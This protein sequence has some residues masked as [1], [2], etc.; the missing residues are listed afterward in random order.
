MLRTPFRGVGRIDCDHCDRD[1]E[2]HRSQKVTE[3]CGWYCCNGVSELFT[4][5]TSP[6]RFT[7]SSAG[8]TKVQVLAADRPAVVVDSDVQ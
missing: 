2:S 4:A 1:V 5:L 7:T 6:H 8:V 3:R